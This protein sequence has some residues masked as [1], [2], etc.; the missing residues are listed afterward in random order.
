MYPMKNE[1]DIRL[2]I[3]RCGRGEKEDPGGCRYRTVRR[4]ENKETLGAGA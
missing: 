4:G 3:R 1:G 2:S